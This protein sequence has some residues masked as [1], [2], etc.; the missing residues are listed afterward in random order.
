MNTT[1]VIA[2]RG[3]ENILNKLYLTI[4]GK[5][6]SISCDRV[7]NKQYNI[8]F[9]IEIVEEKLSYTDE[10][11]GDK[12]VDS[13]LGE[14]LIKPD[15]EIILSNE[16]SSFNNKLNFNLAFD[17][18]C[19]VGVKIYE[20]NPINSHGAL[21]VIPVPT[22][23]INVY[24]YFSE[25]KKVNEK[26]D[27]IQYVFDGYNHLGFFLVDLPRMKKVIELEY[28]K[29]ELDLVV[30]FSTSELIDKLFEEEIIMIVWGIN[31]YTYPI[32]SSEYSKLIKPLLGEEFKQESIF[33]IDEKINELSIVPGYELSTWPKFLEKEWPK[34]K[35]QGKGKKTYLKPFCLK[36]DDSETVITSFLVYREEGILEKNE[37]LLNVD[38]LYS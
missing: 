4:D 20:S 6:N 9:I 29:K 26:T 25:T 18:E 37:P 7:L 38:L 33:N 36:N 16:D 19:F 23:I 14:F 31:P 24:V 12:L 1:K 17:K 15:S 2:T 22:D 10:I 27:D 35:L 34:I 28:G 13:S 21:E 11:L 8:R 30:E 3:G 5:K 32:Y